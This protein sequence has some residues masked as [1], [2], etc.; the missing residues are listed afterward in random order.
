VR[1]VVSDARGL[2][3]LVCATAQTHGPARMLGDLRGRATAD[4]IAAIVAKRPRARTVA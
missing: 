3:R 1:V 2:R 4:A